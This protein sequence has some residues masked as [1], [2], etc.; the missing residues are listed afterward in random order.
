MN[1]KRKNIIANNEISELYTF[2]L[3][4]YP[5]KVL[6]EGKQKDLP[7]VIFLHGG[8]GSPFPFSVGCRGLFPEFTDRFIMVYWDQ[9]GCGAN[10]HVIDEQFTINSFVIMTEELIHEVK[11]LF[12]ENKIFIFATS[13][14]SILSA[15]VLERTKKLVGGV[16]ACGQIVKEIFFNQ[17]VIGE[18]EKAKL[19]VEKL[20]RIKQADVEKITSK[21]MQLVSASIRNYTSGYQNKAGE[22]ASMGGIIRGLLTSPDYSFKDF[23]A[24]MINGYQNNISLW[25]EILKVNLSDTL[26][27]V[28]IPYMMIQGETDIVASTKEVQ[29]VVA[30][31]G[32]ACLQCRVIEK[33]G[34]Y[35]NKAVMDAIFEELVVMA[36]ERKN[37]V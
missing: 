23:K 34:H 28:Q 19:P 27:K 2:S 20:N 29:Q 7:V 31:A 9:L 5:Q 3:G 17:E 36:C 4:G 21:E 1:R 12:P 33:A 15:K 35:P 26:R 14:G 37:E 18:L 13:W 32:N 22:T 11:S 16:V 25:K 30:T 8:P 24:L 10:N 6:I